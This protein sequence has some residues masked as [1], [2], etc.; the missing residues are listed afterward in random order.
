MS[1]CLPW[2]VIILR[3]ERLHMPLMLS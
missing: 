3:P 2:V 1:A